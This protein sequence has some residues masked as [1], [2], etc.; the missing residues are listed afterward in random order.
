MTEKLIFFFKNSSLVYRLPSA[1]TIKTFSM[2]LSLLALFMLKVVNLV[3]FIW[4][5]K[6][7]TSFKKNKFHHNDI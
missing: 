2:L 1:S 7:H 4:C 5:L 6:G 3:N